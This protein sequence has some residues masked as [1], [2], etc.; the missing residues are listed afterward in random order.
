M[1]IIKK[2]SGVLLISVL[3]LTGCF[4][5]LNQTPL[6]KDILTS[7][8][9]YNEPG[10]YKAVLAKVYASYAVTG[11]QGPA[12]QGDISGLDEGFSSYIRLYWKL[13]ELPTDAAVIGWNDGTIQSLSGQSWDAA[14]EFVAATYS[15]IFYTISVA[16]EFLRETTPEKLAERED[17]A[18]QS[19]VDLYRAEARFIRA[20]SYWHALDMFRNPPFVTEQD[21]V[22]AFFPPQTN[23]NELF[24]Y[25][26]T[27]LKELESLLAEPT[28]NEY[29][30]VD[31]AAAWMLLAKLYLNAEV[32][33]NTDRYA[34]ALSYSEQVIN[35]GYNLHPSYEELF[36]ADND[37]ASGIIF[38]IVFDG[39]RTQTFGGTTFLAHASVGGSMDVA[40]FGIDFGWGGI[41]TTSAIVDKFPALGGSTLVA[42]NQGQTYGS[43]T[44]A[45]SFQG[46]EPTSSATVVSSP[47]ADGKFEGYFYFPDANT[48]IKFTD[49]AGWDVNWGD[50][51]ADGT[52]ELGGDNIVVA[53]AG[54]Y[55]VLVDTTNLTYSVNKTTWGLIGDATGSWD[56]DQDMTYD[57]NL[58][59]FTITV[60]LSQGEVKFRANDGWDLNYGDDAGDAILEEGGANIAIPGSGLYTI[61]LYLDAPDHTYSIDRPSFDNRAMFFTEGQNREIEDISQFTEG[62]AVTKWKNVTSTGQPGSD[63]THVDNDFPF[64]RLADAMLMYAEAHLRGGGGD[65]NTALGYVNQ[66]RERGYGDTSGNI[67][68][69]ELTLDFILD[70]RAREFLWE[71]QRR[72]D[73]VRFGRFSETTYLWPWK[74]GTA[75]GRS[76]DSKFDLFPIPNNDLGANINLEQNPGY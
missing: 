39:K 71:G 48:E 69:D 32:Y 15:R 76:T 40:D 45:G 7:A 4:N 30:R 17:E 21:E 31:K 42:P 11:Q 63:L 3:L 13:Q 46:W 34:D 9:V 8:D 74:G 59:A 65:I 54:F 10:A 64:M 20:F 52:L 26:E 41:R 16:N 24:S 67:D 47:A 22:G 37:G 62:Y 28:T 6:D 43:L 27:E 66:I 53:D 23:A 25:I 38:P 73:L 44:V 5:E 70:E 14:S 12:G 60:E 50:T 75:E 35:S 19:E 58:N 56:N 72:T 55:R 61:N 33:I 57:A 49:G 68:T 29:G 2:L 51:G 18:M 1:N 36:L